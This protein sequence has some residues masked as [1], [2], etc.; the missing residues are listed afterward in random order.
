MKSLLSLPVFMLFVFSVAAQTQSSYADQIAEFREQYKMEFKEDQRA[1]LKTDEEFA[2]MRFYPADESYKVA[3]VFEPTPDAKPFE[4]STYSGV[5]KPYRKYGVLLFELNGQRLKLA[6]YESL[7]LKNVPQYQDH[8]FLPFKDLTNGDE[9]YGGGRYIDLKSSDIQD[10]KIMVDFNKAYN[11]WCCY[12]DGYSCPIP[13]TE[14][15][16]NVS[17]PAGEKM[18]AGDHKH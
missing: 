18:Y 13:P 17:V 4:M 6:V 15:H 3:A 14:N 12:S 2:N 7:R 1:P 9:T 16:L 11:P 5:T 8:L 10:G